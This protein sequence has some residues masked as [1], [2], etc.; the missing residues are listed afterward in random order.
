VCTTGDRGTDKSGGLTICPFRVIFPRG[1]RL[2]GTTAPPHKA[3]EVFAAPRL[4]A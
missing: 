1:E 2:L 4:S 3:A